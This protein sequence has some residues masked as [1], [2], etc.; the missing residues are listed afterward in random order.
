[1]SNTSELLIEKN[2]IGRIVVFSVVYFS[3]KSIFKKNKY[4]RLLEVD[5]GSRKQLGFSSYQQELKPLSNVVNNFIS[6]FY[7]GFENKS[8][9]SLGV[10]YF[11]K[12]ASST[13]TFFT[14]FFKNIYQHFWAVFQ[15]GTWIK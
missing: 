14:F 8:H 3:R 4:L 12:P 11:L 7:K 10:W 1:M 6:D 9:L 5:L 15:I 2:E 13:S